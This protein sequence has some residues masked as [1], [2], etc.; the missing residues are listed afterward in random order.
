[1]LLLL[2]EHLLLHKNGILSLFKTAVINAL[3]PVVSD[4]LFLLGVY[5]CIFYQ[6]D[7]ARMHIY[8]TEFSDF[9]SHWSY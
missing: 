1:M 5:K 4:K 8:I 9:F 3:V 2:G 7:Y 6:Q